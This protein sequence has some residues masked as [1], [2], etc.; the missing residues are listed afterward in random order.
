MQVSQ[1]FQV[2]ILEKLL[3]SYKNTNDSAK[4]IQ[5]EFVNLISQDQFN[6]SLTNLELHNILTEHSTYQQNNDDL[7]QAISKLIIQKIKS[8][9]TSIDLFDLL[10]ALK[11]EVAQRPRN[12]DNINIICQLMK[13]KNPVEVVKIIQNSYPLQPSKIS[14]ITVF[15]EQLQKCLRPTEIVIIKQLLEPNKDFSNFTSLF[16]LSVSEIQYTFKIQ[17]HWYKFRNRAMSIIQRHFN[18]KHSQFTARTLI[19]RA[20]IRTQ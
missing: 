19:N 14:S 5:N 20:I 15:L 8:T 13:S 4:L 18:T 9:D 1:E 17:E 2:Q 10:V 6:H 7:D 11:L 12:N 3:K 16:S